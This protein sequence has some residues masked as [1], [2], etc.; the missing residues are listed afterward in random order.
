MPSLVRMIARKK[1]QHQME[2]KLWLLFLI[3]HNYFTIQQNPS[4]NMREHMFVEMRW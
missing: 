3:Y 2:I 4:R 1:L